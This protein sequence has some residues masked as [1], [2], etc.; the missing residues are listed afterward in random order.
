MS[1]VIAGLEDQLKTAKETA[2]LGSIAERLAKNA[3]F[4]RL[5]LE[6]FCVKE[7]AR[8]AQVSGDLAIPAEERAHALGMAQA[9]GHLRR[10]LSLKVQFANLADRDIA[11]LNQAIDEA[12]AEG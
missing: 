11:E 2:E 10:F 6:E 3:D 9:A 4:R 7:C 8:Y 5:I 1:D 12:R